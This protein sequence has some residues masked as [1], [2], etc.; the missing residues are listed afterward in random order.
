MFDPVP[1]KPD[2]IPGEHAILRFWAE[3]DTFE[4]VRAKNEDG[5]TWSFLD[6]PITANNPMGV[7]HAWGR[8]YKDVF[9]RY[10]AMLGHRQRYQNGFD[11]QGLW[12]EVEVE[13]DLGFSTKKDIEAYGIARFVEKC[14]ERVRKYSR[15]QTDQSIRL[16]YWMDWDHS[17]YTMSDENNYTIWSFLK[18]CHDRNLIYKGADVMPWCPRCGTGI[19]QH[20]MHEGYRMVTDPSV[21]LKMPLRERPGESLLVWTTT[22]WTLA[23]NVACAVHPELVYAKVEQDGEVY[24]LSRNRLGQLEGEFRTLGDV[25][26]EQLVGL[27]YD[28]PFDEL[29]AEAE[30]KTAHKVVAWDQVSDE[31]GTGIVH[32]A[33]GC[34]KEDY[35][36]LGEL[37]GFP[38]V[39]PLDDQGG[40]LDGFGE[41]SG[42]FAGDVADAVFDSLK[43]KGV[44]YKTEPYEHSYPHC[45]RC[46]EP[47]LFRLV[48]EWYIDMSWRDEIKEVARQVRWIPEWGLDRELEWLDNMRDWMISKKRYWGLALPIFECACGWFDVVG[49]RDELRRRAIE[50]W[51]T[52]EGHSPHR[53]FVDAVKIECEKCGKPVERIKDVGNP[54]LDAGIVAYS[55]VGYNTDR[56]YWSQWIPADLVT[57]CFPGQFRNWFYAM[58]AMSTMMEHIPPFKTLLGHALVR[59]EHGEEMHKSAGNAIWFDDAAEKMGVDVMRWIFCRHNPVNNLNFGYGVGREIERKVFNTLWNVYAFLAN[60]ARLDGFDPTAQPVPLDERQ[61]LDRWLLSN[62]QLL[63]R[64]AREGFESYLMYGFVE[65]AERFIDDLSN[66]YVRRSRRRFW[67]SHEESDRDKL[68][69]YQ[70]LYTALVTLCK[71]IAPVCPFVAERIYQNLVR[72]TEDAPESVHLCSYPEAD[73]SLIDAE[74]SAQMDAVKDVVSAALGARQAEGLR[75]RQPLPE[76]IVASKDPAVRQGVER[77]RSHVLDELNIKELPLRDSADDLLDYRV[78]PDMARLG[79]R[80]GPKAGAVK[81]ALDAM[82]PAEVAAGVESLDGLPLEINGETVRLDRDDV[83]VERIWPD[84]LAGAEEATFALA[85][86]TVLTDELIQ[87]GIARDVVRHV[88]QL[89]K[90]ADL[91]MDARIRIRYDTDDDG[92]AAAVRQW[93]DYIAAETLALSMDRGL[94]DEP[95][96]VAK[97]SGARIKLGIS[98]V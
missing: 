73:E 34:G 92:V 74:L 6:G 4:K 81:A 87:E 63:V 23:A 52:F 14:K 54:W 93:S 67:R 56:E 33:P 28:G 16:G 90:E 3:H 26:G 43:Q 82:D 42:R 25:P 37:G 66:W 91:E 49:G 58:L 86:N 27:G 2:L 78:R 18:K 95:D 35:D 20:E 88:Q 12:V 75:V 21:I 50:G 70:T 53:P 44:F 60:Y 48:D 57:E 64:A 80:L 61:D 97:V 98:E 19:S 71:L 13:K 17:Y 76:L 9:E 51:E 38:T 1:T 79:P 7:H 39:A 29:P 55:T 96:R 85:L 65:R 77:F 31:E 94:L 22:P 11:C 24:Y 46:S 62:L 69:A 15:I 40:Y 68:A 72:A 84:G 83:I 59:D 30:A 41:L 36:L 45:W 10:H 5:P 8:T 89:R 32:M 47:L